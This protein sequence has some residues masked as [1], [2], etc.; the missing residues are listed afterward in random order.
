MSERE[1]VIHLPDR[2]IF[3]CI[4]ST[5]LLLG[6]IGFFIKFDVAPGAGP[7]WVAHLM[8]AGFV[9]MGTLATV[10]PL[11]QILFPRHIRH[12]ESDQFRSVPREPFLIEGSTVH[13]ALT[14]ELAEVDGAWVLRPPTR[15]WIQHQRV[16]L[17]FGVPFLCIAAGLVSRALRMQMGAPNWPVAIAGGFMITI[18][19]GGSAFLLIGMLIRASYLRLS[20]LKIPK[21]GSDL[22]FD[23]A[24]LPD[25]KKIDSLAGL[26][27]ALVDSGQRKLLKIP[28]ESLRAVQLCAWLHQVGPRYSV[29]S[30]ST[31][32]GNLVLEA[33]GE[34]ARVPLLVS[35]DFVRA[36]RLMHDLAAACEVP[37]LYHATKE[38]WQA[39]KARAR[40]RPPLKAGG[41]M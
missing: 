23:A 20:R 2:W 11:S 31:V 13:A 28:R 19:C 24:S 37:F 9:L 4:G 1:S 26:A 29:S 34:F 36:A 38:D 3:L 39:E 25:E 32:Q 21:D 14:H 7:K 10:L 30:T 17:G 15:L 6:A 18:L 41:S 27:W 8:L 40:T 33:D 12:F 5:F 22:E 16:L 35:G